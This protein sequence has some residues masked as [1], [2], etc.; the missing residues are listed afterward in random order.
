M[1]RNHHTVSIT[2][3]SQLW[4]SKP[5]HTHTRRTA[6]GRDLVASE[7]IGTV[8]LP[9]SRKSIKGGT[10]HLS[11]PTRFFTKF[12]KLFQLQLLSDRSENRVRPT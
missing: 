10:S 1:H 7:A 11:T 6:T 4:N 3:V 12:R 9:A 2:T 5:H 8:H